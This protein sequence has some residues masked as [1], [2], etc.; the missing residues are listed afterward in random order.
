LGLVLRYSFIHMFLFEHSCTLI[1][2]PPYL[3]FLLLNGMSPNCLAFGFPGQSGPGL[4]LHFLDFKTFSFSSA[5]GILG[6]TMECQY[7]GTR[8][9]I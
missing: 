9:P 1:T 3:A 4:D 7:N 6:E 2:G 5:E 8:K